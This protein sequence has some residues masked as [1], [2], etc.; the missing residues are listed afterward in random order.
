MVWR[1]MVALIALMWAAP[2]VAQGADALEGRWALL[3]DGRIVAIL[4]LHRDPRAAGGWTGAWLKPDRLGITSTHEIYGI[5]GPIV[6]RAVMAPTVVSEGLEFAV[7]PRSGETADRF[8]FSATDSNHALFSWA[9][10]LAI[11]PLPF[12]RTSATAAVDPD[13]D[14][15]ARYLVT[16]PA[17]RTVNAE[18]KAI[19]DADQADRRAG[20]AIDWAV[21]APRD[22]AR[23]ARTIQLLNAGALRSGDDFWRAAFIFQHGG[24]ANSYLLA[25]TLA[26]IA[27]ARGRPDATWIA[28]ATLDRYLQT[29]GQKQ[30]YGTQY[31]TR[32][33]QPATR[34]PYDT[35]LISDALRQALGVPALAQQAAQVEEMNR[36]SGQQPPAPRRPR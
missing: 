14:S 5:S 12:V 28:A 22:E 21:V 27:A 16:T 17:A 3:A 36:P 20:A 35:S 7:E 18:M 4:E 13:W 29:I 23:R 32:P 9:D 2:A 1:W 11:P 31:S 26:M 30:I 24:E 19:F 6:R 8:R 33:G 25:H 15:G 10:P 34:E